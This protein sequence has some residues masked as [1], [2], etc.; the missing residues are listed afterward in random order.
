M[1]IGF[2]IP[3]ATIWEKLHAQ[4]QPSQDV[5]NSHL[6]SDLDDLVITPTIY[7][8]RHCPDS[9]GSAGN[10]HSQNISLA[11]VYHSLCRGLVSNLHSMMSASVLRAAG[12]SRI[13]G[14]GTVMTKNAAIR[15]EVERLY[16]MTLVMSEQSEA[17]A[18]FG[19]AMAMRSAYLSQ[20]NADN[21]S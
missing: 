5:V 3:E 9:R 14:S 17:D 16:N 4:Q 7:G 2:G 19:A 10:I 11:S 15:R 8:E 1:P 18:A 12:I 21:S 13:I 6:S 20:S